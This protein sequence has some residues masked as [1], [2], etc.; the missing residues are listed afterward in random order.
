MN[1]ILIRTSKSLDSILTEGNPTGDPLYIEVMNAKYDITKE[2]NFSPNIV[3]LEIIRHPIVKR[4]MPVQII[5]IIFL[6]FPII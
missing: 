5:T 1:M 6:Y 4:P 2:K 3:L